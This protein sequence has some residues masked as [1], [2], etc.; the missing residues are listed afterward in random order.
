M[1]TVFIRRVFLIT[2]ILVAGYL[3]A[4]ALIY[5][6]TNSG[7]YNNPSTW[8]GGLVPPSTLL[9]DVVIIPDGITVTLNQD[10]TLG[11]ALSLL[12]VN[13][14]LNS[15]GNNALILNLGSLNGDGLIDVDSLVLNLNLGLGFTGD[16]ITDDLTS[17]GTILAANAEIT[18]NNLLNLDNGLLDLTS[19]ILNLGN[20]ITIVV[21][22]GKM[23]VNGGLINLGSLYNVLYLDASATTGWELLQPGLNNVEINIPAVAA[24]TLSTDLH[25]NGLLNLTSGI[26]TLNGHDLILGDNCLVGNSGTGLI[27]ADALSDIIVNTDHAL[28]GLLNFTPTGNTV[29]NLVLDLGGTNSLLGLGTDLNVAGL[30]QLKAGLLALNDHILTLGVNGNILGGSNGCYVI[31]GQ[32]GRLMLNV[33]L[34]HADTFHVGTL[35]NYLPCIITPNSGSGSSLLGLGVAAG[36][37]TNGVSGELLSN[38]QPLVNGTWLISNPAGLDLDVQLLWNSAA[39]INGFDRTHAYVSQLLNGQWDIG[40]LVSAL[41]IN[42]MLGLSIGDLLATSVE[43]AVFGENANTTNVSNLQAGGKYSIYPNPASKFIHINNTEAGTTASILITDITGKVVLA[44]QDVVL[45]GRSH[46]LDISDLT[47]GTY[48]IKIADDRNN[49]TASRFVVSQ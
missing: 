46:T 5:T 8:L 49:K 21:S 40:N 6:A 16:I 27:N 7:N 12:T 38:T 39:E 33:D 31:P 44:N 11:G 28:G 35:T 18:V 29:H 9:T 37:F 34:G 36:V 20:N 32:N 13:G 3:P 25:V 41:N 15:S 23:D 24:I 45:G 47:P 2:A 26:L 10:Q 22:G 42:G 14:V 1:F 30:L 43:L 17:L 4:N 19:G 48:F